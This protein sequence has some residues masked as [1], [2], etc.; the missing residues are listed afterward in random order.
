MLSSGLVLD[1]GR[2]ATSI[3]KD[4]VDLW[5]SKVGRQL[6]G[7]L[8]KVPRHLYSCM[9]AAFQPLD[10]GGGGGAAACTH[11][12]LRSVPLLSLSSSFLS[13]L[14]FSS[15]PPVFSFSSGLHP[16]RSQLQAVWGHPCQDVSGASGGQGLQ[17]VWG[18]PRPSQ[19]P[20][21]WVGL[22]SHPP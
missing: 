20:H 2:L 21:S 9:C 12:S 15:L 8:V 14:L 22:H 6:R 18:H 19:V 10:E 11:W 4:R 16:T 3:K 13:R 7:E 17:A 5:W 1:L